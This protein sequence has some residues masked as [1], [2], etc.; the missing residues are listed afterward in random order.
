M[1]W[2]PQQIGMLIVPL[3]LTALIYAPVQGFDFIDYDDGEYVAE[4]PM[5]QQGFTREAI[6][7]AFT[8][9]DAGLWA[10]LT[11]LS[12]ALDVQLFGLW[13]GGHHLVSLLLHLINTVLVFLL[14]RRWLEAPTLAVI[15]AAFFAWH[16]QHVE[17]VAWIASR[18]DVLSGFFFLLTLLAYDRYARRPGIAPMLGVILLFAIALLCKPMVITLPC[19]LLLLDHWPYARYTSQDSPL[20][21]LFARHVLEKL[22]LFG[23]SI[24]AALITFTAET[25]AIVSLEQLSYGERIAH[26]IIS[27]PAY[28]LKAFL[29]VQLV[30]P[31]PY[32]PGA[33]ALHRV[34]FAAAILLALSAFTLWKLRKLPHC[35]VG[36]AWF[37]GMLFPV[38][39]IVAIGHHAMADR[40]TYLPH[41][42][43]LIF[44]LPLLKRFDP[45][46]TPLQ[47]SMAVLTSAC[48]MLSAFQIQHWRDTET[49]FRHTIAVNPDNPIGQNKLGGN[50]LRQ[51]RAEEALPHLQRG[52]ELAPADWELRN[53]LGIA[54]LL[55]R[56]PQQ[57]VT[58]LYPLLEQHPDDPELWCNVGVARYEMG[59]IPGARNCAQ[60][61][62]KVDPNF[63]KAK[64]LLAITG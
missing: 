51:G 64:Q 22:P 27:Y 35:F 26:T 40:F 55:T 63:E 7:Y 10:P 61:A 12:H 62:L 8:S 34:L 46:G 6:V 17:S 3:V 58:T 53:D 60:Q 23:L 33:I 50:L 21:K 24:G 59:D 37:L 15:A 56:Q 32:I 44:I 13:A 45:N 47:A 30:V 48:L 41:L 29:P 20:Y 18:K 16:P 14:F 31:Y 4:N 9:H 43:L 25:D 2:T 54:Y 11:R 57:A 19:V 28:L 52:L 42:G 36:W 49:L 39:G 1:K 38:I 5:A